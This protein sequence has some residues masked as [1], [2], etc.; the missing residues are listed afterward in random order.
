MH[1]CYFTQDSCHPITVIHSLQIDNL[2]AFIK[3]CKGYGVKENFLFNPTEFYEG[4]NT[5]MMQTCLT[6]LGSR[7]NLTLIFKIKFPLMGL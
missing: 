3:F 7:V 4:R 1:F 6:Q 5:G 2:E